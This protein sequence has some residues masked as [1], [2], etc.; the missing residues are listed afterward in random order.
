MQHKTGILDML[1]TKAEM[2]CQTGF[3][4]YTIIYIDLGQPKSV[5]TGPGCSEPD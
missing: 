4:C 5:A 3:S 1:P 2:M